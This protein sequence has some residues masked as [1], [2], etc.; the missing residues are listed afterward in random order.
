MNKESIYRIIG[1]HG[2]YTDGV[3]KAIRKL[4]KEN[5]PDY[6]GDKDIFKLINDVKKELETNQVSFK[7]YNN[8]VVNEYDDIDIEYCKKMIGK[9]EKEKKILSREIN[10]KKEITRNLSDDYKK[11]YR[12]SVE[13]AGNLLKKD[14]KKIDKIKNISILMLIFLVIT[15]IL[16]IVTNKIII[17]IIFGVMCFIFILIIEKYFAIFNEFSK[18]SE[19]KVKKYFHTVDEIRDNISKKT[20]VSSEVIKLER[21]VKKMENDLR[22]YRNLLK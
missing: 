5:H 9:L 22:F 8:N 1:Y 7:Y 20:E 15:F 21:K 13:E 18:K 14:S 16:A 19:M 12:K 2:E 10:T 4:L 6:H 17:F 3:K 11:L